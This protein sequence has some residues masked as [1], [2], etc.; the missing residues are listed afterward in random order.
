MI[1]RVGLFVGIDKYRNGIAPLH[2]AVNDA[3]D[4]SFAFAGAGYQVEYLQNEEGSCDNIRAKMKELLSGLS[5]GDIFV[6]Y[7]AGHGREINASHYLVGPTAEA[8]PRLYSLGSL[9]FAALC[10]LTDSVP[11]L[12]RLFI[13]DCCRNNIL[14]DRADDY[15]CSDARD[16]ALSKAN[17]INGNQPGSNPALILCS[18][19]SGEKAY[20]NLTT[21]HGYFTETLL[22]SIKDDTISSFRQ[23]QDSLQ[24]TGTPGP[25]N[26]TWNGSC[27]AW[28]DLM[29]FRHWETEKTYQTEIPISQRM[30]QR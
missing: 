5:S 12:N 20:E 22:R 15:V 21:N 16:I 24:I 8:D 25:Q 7:F 27:S 19:A 11:G 30:N 2:C 13:L 10:N 23:F 18:C 28:N 29:L 9:E 14:S 4:L 17:K 6:F 1:K 26:I 3:K